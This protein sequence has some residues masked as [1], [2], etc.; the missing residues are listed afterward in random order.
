MYAC[1]GHSALGGGQ[2]TRH[3]DHSAL[4]GSSD[5]KE[6]EGIQ[7]ASRNIGNVASSSIAPTTIPGMTI[8]QSPCS[9]W[10]Q[11]SNDDENH[12]VVAEVVI[13]SAN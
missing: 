8:L 4:V 6:S 1:A 2:C 7:E 10:P 9:V 11:K 12:A 13:V 3:V 5:V